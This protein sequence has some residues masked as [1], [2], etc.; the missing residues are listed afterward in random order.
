MFCILSMFY[1]VCIQPSAGGV[2]GLCV[3]PAYIFTATLT[4]RHNLMVVVEHRIKRAHRSAL[5]RE[6]QAR[7]EGIKSSTSSS[8]ALLLL[9]N[10]SLS[11]STQ[12]SVILFFSARYMTTR[13][14]F[15]GLRAPRPSRWSRADESGS[16]A[17]PLPVMTLSQST[18]KVTCWRPLRTDC[19]GARKTRSVTSTA[20]CGSRFESI[21]SC[22]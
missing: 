5:P 4:N 8:V 17:A 12:M 1:V 3:V 10:P 18:E 2:C 19:C 9:P 21:G 20:S 22:T 14:I 11:T 7:V 16:S 13:S 6:R 15:G